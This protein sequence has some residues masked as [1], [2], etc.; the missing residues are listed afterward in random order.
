LDIVTG[1]V[2][3]DVSGVIA[4]RAIEIYA[5]TFAYFCNI[6]TGLP[7]YLPENYEVDIILSTHHYLFSG[8][9]RQHH[10]QFI[11]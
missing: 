9:V 7:P 5:D 6:I 4:A 2:E 3:N 10:N 8:E 11:R 1:V